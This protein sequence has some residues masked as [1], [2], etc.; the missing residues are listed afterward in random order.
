MVG[1][2]RWLLKQG[3]GYIEWGGVFCALQSCVYVWKFS[4]R[5]NEPKTNNKDFQRASTFHNCNLFDFSDRFQLSSYLLAFLDISRGY[6]LWQDLPGPMLVSTLVWIL[7]VHFSRSVVSDSLWSHGLQQARLPCQSPTTRAC[8]NSSPS[9]QWCHPTILSSEVLA[10][11]SP[12]N[13]SQHQGLF[14]W[15]S[16]LRQV[17]KVL[18]FQLQHQSFQWI[19]SMLSFRIDWFDLLAI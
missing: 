4:L 12:F 11:P 8:S 18:E 16:S 9:S 5:V 6:F 2:D 19:F 17:A 13:L 1:E 10:S 15:V 7:S 14:S 3:D